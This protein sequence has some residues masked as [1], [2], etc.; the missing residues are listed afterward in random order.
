MSVVIENDGR[1]PMKRAPLPSTQLAKNASPA[2]PTVA[3]SL[4]NALEVKLIPTA[5]IN[6]PEEK[7]EEKPT[8]R[9][10]VTKKPTMNK[11]QEQFNKNKADLLV[12]ESEKPSPSLKKEPSIKDTESGEAEIKDKKKYSLV[13]EAKQKQEKPET[14]LPPL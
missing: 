2:Q 7:S 4:N 1:S 5:E 3:Q 14:S 8:N 10:I 9:E 13:T 11:T 6:E 12:S